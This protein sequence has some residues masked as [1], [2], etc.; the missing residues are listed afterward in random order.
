MGNPNMDIDTEK[1]DEA[2]LALLVLT[3]HD[4]FRAWKSFDWQAMNRLHQRGWIEDPINT[5]KSVALTRAG[6]EESGRLF[7]ELFCRSQATR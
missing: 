2:V 3:L 7:R 4:G 6:A 1:I 5:A